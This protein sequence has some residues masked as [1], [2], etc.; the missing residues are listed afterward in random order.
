LFDRPNRGARSQSAHAGRIGGDIDAVSSRVN[1]S[2]Q[3][4]T[5]ITVVSIAS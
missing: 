3:V 5:D 4:S 2:P 1:P